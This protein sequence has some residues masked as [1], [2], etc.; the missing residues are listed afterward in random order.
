ME[1][2]GWLIFLLSNMIVIALVAFCF[3]KVFSISQEHMKA[4]LAIDTKD[5]N[6]STSEDEEDIALPENDINHSR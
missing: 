1:P 5:L 4:P 2:I 6:E 3:Y